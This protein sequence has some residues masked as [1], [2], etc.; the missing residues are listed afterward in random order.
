MGK[1]YMARDQY[2]NT[3][4]NLGPY[5]RKALLERFG[6]KNCQKM[7]IDTPNG[8]EHIGWVIGHY[9]LEVFE[10]KPLHEE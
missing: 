1:M 4:H 3:Y 10:V 9:W 7:Y 8:S 5:P 2:G 6:R